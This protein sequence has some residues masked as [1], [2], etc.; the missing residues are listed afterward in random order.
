MESNHSA[1]TENIDQND[2]PPPPAPPRT[3]LDRRL[4]ALIGSW[5]SLP[6][7]TKATLHFIAATSEEVEA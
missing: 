1:G 2:E 7:N 4:L 5:D 3:G 6:E